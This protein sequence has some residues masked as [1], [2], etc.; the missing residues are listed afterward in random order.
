MSIVFVLI[1]TIVALP[2]TDTQHPLP[3]EVFQVNE[4]PIAVAAPALVK[5]KDGYSL[6][7]ELTNNSEFRA[8]GLRYSLAVVDSMNNIET[9][10]NASEGLKL[11]PY[12][13]KRVNFRIPAKLEVKD[14][15]RLVFVLEQIVSADYVWEVTKVKETFA[16]YIGG[17]YSV[18][19]HVVRLRNQID[20]PP[21]PRVIY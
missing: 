14:D 1:L 4:L 5:N 2:Q 16:A 8:T 10:I 11:A 17:D 9:L 7:C 12:Q 19:P 3:V 15:E 21:Q 20:A 13:T 18:I 6:K